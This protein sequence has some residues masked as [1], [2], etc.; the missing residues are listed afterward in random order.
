MKLMLCFGFYSEIAEAL[1]RIV[2]ADENI[3]VD[4][5][6]CSRP[7]VTVRSVFLVY[8]LDYGNHIFMVYIPF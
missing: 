7:A 5:D 3:Q 6:I 4:A 2:V 1:V 8:C